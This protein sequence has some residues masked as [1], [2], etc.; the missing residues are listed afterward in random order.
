[1]KTG[2]S[3]TERL[4][5]YDLQQML[6]AGKQHLFCYPF[7]VVYLAFEADHPPYNPRLASLADLPLALQKKQPVA[8][9]HLLGPFPA[10]CLISA[11]A[12]RFKRAVDRNRIKRLTREAFRKN[13]SPFYAF[14]KENNLFCLLAFIYSASEILPFREIESKMAVSLQQL[15]NKLQATKTT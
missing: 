10:Q 11:P 1:M 14:L 9:R 4:C 5:S 8:N 6:F 13:K 12:K 7:R 3:K 2:F 15:T